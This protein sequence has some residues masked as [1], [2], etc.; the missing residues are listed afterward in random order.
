MKTLLALFTLLFISTT[1]YAQ[2]T[3]YWNYG[4]TGIDY[5]NSFCF[6][7][8]GGYALAGSTKSYGASFDNIYVVKVDSLGSQEW[9]YYDFT[10]NT[11]EAFSITQT[12]DSGFIIGAR[13]NRYP[14]LLKLDSDGNVEW[15]KVYDYYNQHNDNCI[16]SVVQT[17]DGGFVFTGPVYTNEISFYNMNF[18]VVKTDA[19]GDT[20]WTKSFGGTDA[21]YSSNIIATSDSNYVMSGY[22]S[23]F[24]A[25]STDAYIMKISQEGDSIWGHS[26]GV[27]QFDEGRWVLESLD[28]T[29]VLFGKKYMN[30][31]YNGDYYFWELDTL[32]N[33]VNEVHVPKTEDV[34][35][36]CFDFTEDGGFIIL[37]NDLVKVDSIGN[38]EWSRTPND[39]FNYLRAVDDGFVLTGRNMIDGMDD[40]AI[41]RKLGTDGCQ[42]MSV[43]ITGD[44]AICQ[45]N[46]I[47]LSREYTGD[48]IYHNVWSTGSAAAQITVDEEGVYAVTI[49]DVSGCTASDSVE[50]FYADPLND[51]I[52]IGNPIDTV[53]WPYY[54]SGIGGCI[55]DSVYVSAAEGY[56]YEWSTGDTTAGV[57]TTGGSYEM[58]VTDIYGCST[59]FGFNTEFYESGSG[60]LVYTD[61][62]ACSYEGVQVEIGDYNEIYQYWMTFEND[63][64]AEALPQNFG[65]MEPGLAVL[66]AVNAICMRAVDSAEFVIWP[67]VTFDLLPFEEFGDGGDLLDT[68]ICNND[69]IYFWIE[70]PDLDYVY[71]SG[72]NNGSVDNGVWINPAH[73]GQIGVNFHAIDEHG[74]YTINRNVVIHSILGPEIQTAMNLGPDACD[75]ETV[76]LINEDF[77]GSGTIDYYWNNESTAESVS[78]E[79]DSLLFFQAENENGCVFNSDTFNIVFHPNPDVQIEPQGDTVLCSN[80]YVQLNI[81]DSETTNLYYWSTGEMSESIIADTTGVFMLEAVSPFG[82]TTIAEQNV[83]VSYTYQDQEICMVTVDTTE[84]KN[85]VVWEKT[86]VDD[87]YGYVIYRETSQTGVYEVLDTVLYD[88]ESIFLDTTS[89]PEQHHNKYKISVIDSCMIESSLSDYHRTMH[90]VVSDNDLTSFMLVWLEYMGTAVTSY[91][92]Y[93]GTSPENLEWIGAIASSGGDVNT[94]LDNTITPGIHYYYQVGVYFSEGCYSNTGSKIQSGPFSYSFSNLDDNVT[95]PTGKNEILSSKGLKIFPNPAQNKAEVIL[96]ETNQ[97]GILELQDISG[98]TLNTIINPVGLKHT[99]DCSNLPSG[100]YFVKYK[101]SKLFTGKL[102]VE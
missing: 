66:Y 9:F 49:E 59:S 98:R 20:I 51:S 84:W 5:S 85:L 100:I 34:N 21:D 48:N 40:Q 6:T 91:D 95:D 80:E 87:I 45:G 64:V 72:A 65:I 96:P 8:D 31:N 97:Q 11:D 18:W 23:S 102:V 16:K 74:C 77:S 69:S 19:L 76:V 46:L 7:D 50:T 35:P 30:T 26:F 1:I 2:S 15:E 33:L 81:I 89:D 63:S 54:A 75:G 14:Y 78:V 94:W 71:E 32:G 73:D 36:K 42:E 61:T 12:A 62:A 24:G 13:K 25:G 86:V 58:T 29:Y 67:Q 4:H 3:F 68:S 55:G 57:Y 17:A 92:I 99:I 47:T 44:T 90:L 22:T 27:M 56:F 70:G 38:E 101:G 53:M 88:D 39:N 79:E 41:L 28:S 60:S 83:I 37:G 43:T 10:D 52:Y 93:R 82:C